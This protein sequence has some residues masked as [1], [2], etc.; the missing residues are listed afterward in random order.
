MVPLTASSAARRRVG[1][2][3]AGVALACAMVVVSG[4]GQQRVGATTTFRREPVNAPVPRPFTGSVGTDEA[5]VEPPENVTGAYAGTTPGLYLDRGAVCDQ[6][7]LVTALDANPTTAAVWA[8][9]VGIAPADIDRYVA[10]LTPVVLRTDTAVT[11]HGYENGKTTSIPAVLQAGTAVLVDDRGV[12]AVQC[13]T[14]NVLTTAPSSTD[15]AYD[16]PSWA[17]FTAHTVTTVKPAPVPISSIVVADVSGA[18]IRRPIG[19]TGAEDGPYTPGEDEGAPPT[20]S[21]VPVTTTPPTPEAPAADYPGSASNYPLDAGPTPAAVATTTYLADSSRPG[22]ADD[23]GDAT[24]GDCASAAFLASPFTI[25]V[26]VRND[27]GR[28]RGEVTVVGNGWNDADVSIRS[29]LPTRDLHDS[30]SPTGTFSVGGSRHYDGDADQGAFS[31]RWS[32]DL[33]TGRRLPTS[34]PLTIR[35]TW[36][37]D[38]H[39]VPWLTSS[40]GPDDS[41][42]VYVV[43]ANR[44]S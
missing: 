38:V 13:R 4:C 40:G 32:G 12:P 23:P 1:I 30:V 7:A 37:R 22:G 11:N 15:S 39:V 18:G 44:Q 20:G 19:T 25:T 2:R 6:A 36:V 14:G 27:G 34:F 21:T 33:G 8:G 10:T 41:S 24:T 3:A 31:S 35:R 17:G 28:G 43:T 9:L 26:R 16:G 29:P 5:G 42:C